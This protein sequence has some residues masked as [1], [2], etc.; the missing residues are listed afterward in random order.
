MDVLR[1]KRAANAITR[2][3]RN[4]PKRT[5][6]KLSRAARWAPSNPFKGEYSFVRTVSTNTTGYAF[7]IQTDALG[8]TTFS[9]GANQSDNFQLDFSL[10]SINL[11][12]GGVNQITAVVPNY[13]EFTN[14]FDQWCIDKVEVMFIPTYSQQGI[15]SAPQGN[16]P[17]IVHALDD[18]D[19]NAATKTDLQQYAN[20]KYTQLLYGNNDPKPIRTFRPKPAVPVYQTGA[21]FAYGQQTKGPKW[22]DVAYPAVPHYSMKG[23]LDVASVASTVFNTVIAR[24]DVVCKMH[25]RFKTVR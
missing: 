19:S 24:I 17:I 10:Q 14:L 16:I 21:T 9:V 11:K 6:W 5:S 12:L 22:V 2:A 20:C 7:A 25:F 18:D 23:A 4:R 8:F 3:W 13:T 1:R 15:S